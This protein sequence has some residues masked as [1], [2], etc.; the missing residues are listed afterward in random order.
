MENSAAVEN[1]EGFEKS[2]QRDGLGEERGCVECSEKVGH[3]EEVD[4]SWPVEAHQLGIWDKA[5]W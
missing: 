3:E 4:A 1:E 2:I 5:R